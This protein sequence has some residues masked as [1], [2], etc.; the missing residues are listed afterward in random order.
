MIHAIEALALEEGE[1]ILGT[2]IRLIQTGPWV[3]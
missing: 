2:D 3:H 1:E